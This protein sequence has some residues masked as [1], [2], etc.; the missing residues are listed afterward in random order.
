MSH[1]Y[2]GH[3]GEHLPALV[4][5]LPGAEAEVYMLSQPCTYLSRQLGWYQWRRWI[6]PP[7]AGC[8]VSRGARLLSG[9]SLRLL[10]SSEELLEIGDAGPGRGCPPPPIGMLVGWSEVAALDLMVWGPHPGHLCLG[11]LPACPQDIPVESRFYSWGCMPTPRNGP[12]ACTIA[13]L[14]W[15][16]VPGLELLSVLLA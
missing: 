2:C 1:C 16:L 8:G 12:G 14:N 7:W 15:V 3:S 13:P 6:T 11:L 10:A 9:T 4:L 5:G